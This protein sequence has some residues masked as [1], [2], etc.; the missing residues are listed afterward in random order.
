MITLTQLQNEL[1]QWQ[2]HNFPTRTFEEPFKGIV[3]EVG[4]LSH[5]LLKQKQGIRGTYDEHEAKIK[6]SV[7]DILVYLA[8]FCNARGYNLQDIIDITWEQV[9][10]RDWRKNPK[11]AA[12]IAEQ[13]FSAKN[14]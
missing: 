11:D 7:G 6:D 10:A 8:D 5:G 14:L 1:T 12:K 4:E 9:R 3:E 13:Q 2:A